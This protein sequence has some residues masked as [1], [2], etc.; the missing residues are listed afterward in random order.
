MLLSFSDKDLGKQTSHGLPD[1]LNKRHPLAYQHRMQMDHNQIH[2]ATYRA[3]ETQ[4]RA[5][6][7]DM[8]AGIAFDGHSVSGGSII[9]MSK[10]KRQ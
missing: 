7:L 2:P 8:A 9:E 5:M 4:C 3:I 10:S 1:I 6:T